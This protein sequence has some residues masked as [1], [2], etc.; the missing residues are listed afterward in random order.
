[1]P[2]IKQRVDSVAPIWSEICKLGEH[3]IVRSSM[4][5]MFVVPL[6]A[7]C[8]MPL[9]FL[10]FSLGGRVMT[11]DLALPFHWTLLYGAA[12]F[13]GVGAVFFTACCPRFIKTYAT[14]TSLREMG[15]GSR[16]TIDS[17]VRHARNPKDYNHICDRN[18]ILGQFAVDYLALSREQVSDKSV[19]ERLENGTIMDARLNEAF[20]FVSN[21]CEHHK[22]YHRLLVVASF[23]IGALFLLAIMVKNTVYVLEAAI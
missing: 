6:A 13:F 2:T 12:L 1:M 21:F 9:D 23:S 5:W 7:R 11:I 18:E 19:L 20:W 10:E 4:I 15:K 14:P 16:T 8:L 22:P 3:K 17:L